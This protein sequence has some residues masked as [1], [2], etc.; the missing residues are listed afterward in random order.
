MRG[1]ATSVYFLAVTVLVGLLTP[2]ARSQQMSSFDRARALGMLDEVARDV[3]KYY[4]DPTFHGLDWDG[5]LTEAKDK[6]KKETSLN[7]A[8]AHI[9]AAVISLDDSHT[10]FLPPPRP[11]RH[12]YGFQTEMIGNQCFVSRVRP[13]SDAEAQGVKPG[14]E[15]LAIEG[16]APDRQNLWKMDYRFKVLRPQ[17]DLQI[18]LRDPAGHQRQV[19]VKAKIVNLKRVADLT[20]GGGGTDIW[21]LLREAENE[22]HRMRVRSNSFGDELLIAKLPAFFFDQQEVDGLVDKARK[23]Q[24]LILDLRGNPGGAV[25]TLKYMLGGDL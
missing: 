6:I 12:D 15:V 2:A 13:G 20:G 3:R 8:L 19:A 14:D 9:A 24:A 7:M 11:Y 22:E 21:D 17:P 18:A 25:E 10:F 23:H 5:K 1:N 4:Y 16:Y